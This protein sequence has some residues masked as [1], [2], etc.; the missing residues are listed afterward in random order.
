MTRIQSECF[1]E[2]WEYQNGDIDCTTEPY[3]I[4]SLQSDLRD[5]KVEGHKT[6]A[7]F[8]IKPSNIPLAERL[9]ARKLYQQ[10]N[11]K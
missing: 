2:V 8:L 3:P 1:I 5:T 6:T 9:E 10:N 11:V 7:V 4:E